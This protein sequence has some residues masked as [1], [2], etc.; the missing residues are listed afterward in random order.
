MDI[1]KLNFVWLLFLVSCFFLLYL[2]RLKYW[3]LCLFYTKKAARPTLDKNIKKEYINIYC[4]CSTIK[5]EMA[6]PKEINIMKQLFVILVAVFVASSFPAASHAGGSCP[7]GMACSENYQMPV[8]QGAPEGT[9]NFISINPDEELEYSK[10]ALKLDVTT[11]AS[12]AISRGIAQLNSDPLLARTLFETCERLCAI[13]EIAP[14]PNLRKLQRIATLKLTQKNVSESLRYLEKREYSTAN[15]YLIS[16]EL[17]AN[18]I[19]KSK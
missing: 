13:A 5:P 1:G 15:S 19:K 8:A 4:V 14:P 10:G 16:A 3:F 17:N 7:S 11:A 6:H 12:E 18:S 2:I 9:S